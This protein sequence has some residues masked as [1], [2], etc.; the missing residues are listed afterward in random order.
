LRADSSIGKLAARQQPHLGHRIEAAL[1]VGIEGADRVDLVAEEVDAIRHR[2]AHR[3]E[4]DQAAAHRVFA[5]RDDLADVGVAGERQLRL[6]RRFVE[7]L[8]GAEVKRRAGDEARRCEPHERRRRRHQDD[9]DLA[10]ADPPQRLEPLGDEV[11]VRRE[12]V[13]R[14]RLP[15]G[16]DG[17]AQLRRE[18]RDLV[19]E[20]LRVGGLGAE[21]RDGR[22]LG[23]LALGEAREQQSVGRAGR[24]G[25]REALAGCDVGEEHDGGSQRVPRATKVSILK[26]VP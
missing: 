3:K 14:Q 11:L 15:V 18:E 16:E 8:L 1:R 10:A 24:A 20:A 6:Q 21:D 13:V 19:G 23:T 26:G 4:V 25:Q 5:R 22:A 17:D 12:R 9:V 2:R 7:L